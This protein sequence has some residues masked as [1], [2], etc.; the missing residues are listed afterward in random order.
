MEQR[1]LER[2]DLSIPATLRVGSDSEES[3][4]FNLLTRDISSGGA[5]LHTDAPLPEG[6][7]IK[8]DLILPIDKLK[9]LTGKQAFIKV[10]GIVIRSESSGMAIC[11][12]PTYK[13]KS[14]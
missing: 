11:F 13:I 8:M 10:K 2:F 1:S 7:P 9:E 3:V 6:T 5:F 14:V 4:S 12:E